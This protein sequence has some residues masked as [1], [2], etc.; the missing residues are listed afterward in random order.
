MS[1]RYAGRAALAAAVALGMPSWSARADRP[2]R[3]SASAAPA[4]RPGGGVFFALD[5]EEITD[6]GCGELVDAAAWVAQNPAGVVVVEGPGGELGERRAHAVRDYLL[7]L[8]VMPQQM[9]VVPLG[10]RPASPA[11]HSR[12]VVLTEG[13]RPSVRLREIPVPAPPPPP[14]VAEVPQVRTEGGP[15]RIPLALDLLAGGGVTA[16]VGGAGDV[17]RMGRMWTARVVGLRD[18][19]VGFEA[20]YVGSAQDIAALGRDGDAT[21]IGH[22]VEG[23]VRLNLVRRGAVRPYAVAGLGWTHYE[24]TAAPVATASIDQHD[25][26]LQVPVGAGVS[27]PLMQRTTLDVRGTYRGA[28]EDAPPTLSA[29]GQL[30][31]AF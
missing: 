31:F 12:R 15:R 21:L 25:D 28:A 5:S 16:L 22:G 13:A 9:V 8:G 29:T 30:G 19:L 7:S 24:V 26:V 4:P 18:R 3:T 10:E 2:V 14:P 23:N 11:A 1:R 20:A 6:H 27:V 17:T